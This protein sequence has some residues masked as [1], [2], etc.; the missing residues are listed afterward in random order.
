MVAPVYAHASKAKVFAALKS[1]PDCA[2][3]C[4]FFRQ[5]CLV[6]IS[7]DVIDKSGKMLLKSGIYKSNTIKSIGYVKFTN[8]DGI[9]TNEISIQY[10]MPAG[11]KRIKLDTV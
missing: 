11:M 3:V 10:L 7:N 5:N 8:S 4:G 9:S 2:E 6:E 1:N